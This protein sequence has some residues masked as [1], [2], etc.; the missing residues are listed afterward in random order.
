M[1]KFF[2]AICAFVCL[3]GAVACTTVEPPIDDTP[4]STGSAEITYTIT[5][6]VGVVS[7]GKYTLS[8][9][10]IT[11]KYGDPIELPTPTCAGYTFKYWSLKSREF[12]DTVFT[13]DEDI[14]LVAEWKENDW[15]DNF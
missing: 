5:L 15:P 6:D 14:V 11:V 10:S 4:P 8:T 2:A 9:T 3:L 1:K 13:L 7:N 12:T